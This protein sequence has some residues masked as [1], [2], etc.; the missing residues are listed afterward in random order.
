VDGAGVDGAGVDDAGKSRRVNMANIL[1]EAL[2]LAGGYATF[3]LVHGH[4]GLS[5]PIAVGTGL[6][7]WFLLRR[8]MLTRPLMGVLGGVALGDVAAAYLPRVPRFYLLAGGGVGGYYAASKLQAVTA[9]ILAPVVQ[10]PVPSRRQLPAQAQQRAQATVLE[11]LPDLEEEEEE[12]EE[13]AAA[14]GPVRHITGS[15]SA[16]GVDHDNVVAIGGSYGD[17]SLNGE[18]DLEQVFADAGLAVKTDNGN[19]KGN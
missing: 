8:G 14:V 1:D 7:T 6:V 19:G 5:K 12:E 17:A 13:A 18:L 3:R 16:N 2:A 11:P 9:Q 15:D 10:A 4:S